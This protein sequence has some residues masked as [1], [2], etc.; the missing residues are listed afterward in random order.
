MLVKIFRSTCVLALAV[1][2]SLSSAMAAAPA[3]GKPAPPLA[4]ADVSGHRVDL[5]A[6]RGKVV[7]LNFWATWCAPCQ[8]EIPAFV[9]WQS[10]FAS[11][12]LQV[13]GV[14]MDDEQAQ[15]LHYLVRHKLNY[16]VVM[17]DDKLGEAYGG[18]DGLPIT[19]LIDRQGKIRAEF[20]G[21]TDI[22]R[23]LGQLKP[24]LAQR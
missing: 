21:E 12:G 2:L 13:V 15:V 11:Q 14:S 16:P 4:R 5:A 24:L 1:G 19:F 10:Q 6:L 18:V 17:G 22:N 8:A 20:K 23:I 9:A 7:L 3:I